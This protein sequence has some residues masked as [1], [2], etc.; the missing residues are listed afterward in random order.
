MSVYQRMK[1][2]FPWTP[3]VKKG[4]PTSKTYYKIPQFNGTPG[5]IL[6][7]HN[8][9]GQAEA[10]FVDTQDRVTTLPMV[11]D[12]RMCCDTVLRATRLSPSVYVIPD[13]WVL[14]GKKVFDTDFFEDR[15]QTVTTLL[16]TFHNP[17]LTALISVDDVPDAT[18]IRGYEWYDG[19][20]GS[21]GIFVPVEE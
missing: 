3:S 2:L 14:N 15:Q 18:P 16:E 21:F 5:W 20:P 11:I 4:Q 12:E 19:R 8:D 1:R 17:V 10:V 9:D 6:L 7:S 13:I